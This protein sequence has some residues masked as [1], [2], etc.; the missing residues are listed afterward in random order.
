MG[1]YSQWAGDVEDYT[2]EEVS[3]FNVGTV[4]RAHLEVMAD[5]WQWLQGRREA[6]GLTACERRAVAH[7]A[8]RA[9]VPGQLRTLAESLYMAVTAPEDGQ[10]V[11]VLEPWVLEEWVE[12]P[13]DPPFTCAP[14]DY[15]LRCR[16]QVE[17]DMAYISTMMLALPRYNRMVQKSLFP[18]GMWSSQVKK[19]CN[20]VLLR[21]DRERME[22]DVAISKSL[23]V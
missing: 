3:Q 17:K 20:R 10:R 15:F 23:L 21:L 16:T 4:A 19:L 1:A 12:D 22:W 2:D 9:A 13:D 14:A 8:G 11:A 18:E 7:M 5:C 6:G